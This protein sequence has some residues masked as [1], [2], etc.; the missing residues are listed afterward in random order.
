MV[1][2]D[3]GNISLEV[4]ETI[5]RVS[6]IPLSDVVDSGYSVEEM[7]EENRDCADEDVDNVEWEVDVFGVVPAADF[8]ALKET[9][10][11]L[12]EKIKELEKGKE[13]AGGKE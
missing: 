13:F 7:A 4:V 11:R 6:S 9:C 3:I 2:V 5:T 12:K 10:N 8:R 1:K